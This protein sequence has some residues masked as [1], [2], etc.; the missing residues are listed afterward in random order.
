M[1]YSPSGACLRDNSRAKLRVQS[2][3]YLILLSGI[4]YCVIGLG[5]IC[6]VTFVRALHVRVRSPAFHSLFSNR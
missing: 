4:V 1:L 3:Y 6:H 5:E 2:I